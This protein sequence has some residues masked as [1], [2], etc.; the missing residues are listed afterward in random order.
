MRGSTL[1]WETLLTTPDQ[2]SDDTLYFIYENPEKTEGSLYLGKKLISGHSSSGGSNIINIADL[3]DIYIDGDSLADAQILVYNETSE[4]WENA[5]LSTII[6]TTV[7]EFQGATIDSA[8]T[9]GLV[10]VPQAGDQD[11]FLSGDGTWKTINVPG[12]NSQNFEINSNIISLLD[13]STA[14]VGSIPIKTS[15]G[16]G[17]TTITPSTLS[18]QI[19][20]LNK[21]NQQLAGI[22]PE[23]LNLN[24]IYMVRNDEGDSSNNRYDEYMIIN[25]KI[26]LLG[27]FG[28]VDLE[29][30]VETTIFNTTVSALENRLSTLENKNFITQSEIGYLGNL[31][32][33]PG[34]TTLIEE[35]NDINLRLQWCELDS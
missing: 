24:A 11:K 13:F 12:F 20:T 21:L 29:D 17:W 9:N 15:T 33:S 14:E 23:P 7:G 8:G 5:S 18:R 31:I 30:Y 32:L 35:V 27:T 3:N 26:E 22:D 10:P 19:T 16:L 6:N 34:N 25:N 2:I 1:A 4:Q 28:R